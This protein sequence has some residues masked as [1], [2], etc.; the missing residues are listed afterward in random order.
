M[1][2]RYQHYLSISQIVV[3]DYTTAIAI[4][5]FKIATNEFHFILSF[6]KMLEFG[7]LIAFNWLCYF[8]R[9]ITIQ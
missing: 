8:N 1:F 5:K 6:M 3:S 2:Y 9:D 4:Y 7:I